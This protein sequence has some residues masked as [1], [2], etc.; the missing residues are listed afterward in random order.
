MFG[1]SD[2]PPIIELGYFKIRLK[3]HHLRYLLH[4]LKL[5]HEEWQPRDWIDWNRRKDQLYKLNPLV[6][7]PYFREGDLVVSKPG[8]IALAICMR[9]GRKDLIG[10]TP[11]KL[12]MVR[13]LQSI[14]GT[15]FKLA[16]SLILKNDQE[17]RDE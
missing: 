10:N 8:A 15:L 17:I 2:P 11:Q 5:E 7:I 12:V 14:L 1:Q 6:T 13:I 9:A 4:Y 16:A 3:A